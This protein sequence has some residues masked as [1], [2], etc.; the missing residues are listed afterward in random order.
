MA[1]ASLGGS[2][3]VDSL[4]FPASPNA[5]TM[6]RHVN[7][8]KAGAGRWQLKKENQSDFWLKS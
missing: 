1:K 6:Y 5:C 2:L 7:Y 4:A 3:V 8:R